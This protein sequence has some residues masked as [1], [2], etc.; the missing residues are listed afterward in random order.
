M[1]LNKLS[2]DTLYQ[3]NLV[4]STELFLTKK[5]LFTGVNTTGRISNMYMMFWACTLEKGEGAPTT[6]F[7]VTP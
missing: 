7:I 3:Q 1:S 2:L 4:F 6:K 5:K